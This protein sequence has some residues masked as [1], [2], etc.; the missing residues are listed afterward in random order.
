MPSIKY[1]GSAEFSQCSELLDKI[2]NY[3]L[4]IR[5]IIL[6]EIMQS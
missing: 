6:I 4:I 5:N 3:A 1:D 2:Q